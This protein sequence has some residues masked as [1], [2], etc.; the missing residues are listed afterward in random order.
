MQRVVLFLKNIEP[1]EPKSLALSQNPLHF[2]FLLYIHA[3]V[4][5]VKLLKSLSSVLEPDLGRDTLLTL[6]YRANDSTSDVEDAYLDGKIKAL[7]NAALDASEESYIEAALAL[8]KDEP[9]TIYDDF[10]S[11]AEGCAESYTDKDGIHLLIL[12]PILAWSRYVI[13]CGKM[14]DAVA[15]KVASLYRLY[16]A[17]PESRVTVGNTLICP[18]H[19]PERLLE[20]RQ[21]LK[22]LSSAKEKT[23]LVDTSYLLTESPVPDFSDTRY[24]ALSVTA[25]DASC[26]FV[27]SL[28]DHIELSHRFM[29]FSLKVRE[30]LRSFTTGSVIDV[31]YPA[32]FFAAWRQT[33]LAMRVFALKALVQ[34]VCVGSL[35]PDALIATTAVFSLGE[36]NGQGPQPE[37]RIG[38]SLKSKP[39]AVVAGVVWPCEVPELESTQDFAGQI[40]FSQ[41]VK[42]IVSHDVRF[43]LEWSEHCGTPLY[44]NPEGF[45][46]HIENPDEESAG[47]FAPTLN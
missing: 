14:P 12:L 18:E 41:G 42:S 1:G 9:G 27:D 25:P 43:P 15:L 26:L 22:T 20:V 17:G 13:V 11:L 6:A 10:L 35:T 19:I 47:P 45:V 33:A 29:E 30:A 8:L 5:T 16:F 4:M 34:Y 23:A 24:I 44:A 7:C 37:I 3:T 32:A 40:L 28:I 36:E 46:T 21:L 38:I 2:R 39:N 31:Q